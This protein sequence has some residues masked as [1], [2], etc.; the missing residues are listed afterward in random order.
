METVKCPYCMAD[1]SVPEDAEE[2][3]ILK[4]FL[5]WAL[6]HPIKEEEVSDDSQ[7]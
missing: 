4:G 2:M 6:K 5:L 1:V 3:T 7:A